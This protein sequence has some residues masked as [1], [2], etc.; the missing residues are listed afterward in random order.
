[1]P[2]NYSHLSFIN[3]ASDWLTIHE[4]VDL[5]NKISEFKIKTCDIYRHALYGNIY[6]SIYFQSHII[7]RKVHVSKHK[8]NLKPTKNSLID[9]LCQL[10]STILLAGDI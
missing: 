2:E 10:E 5:I 7:L 9:R 4:A 8:V 3:R 6:L 1:M